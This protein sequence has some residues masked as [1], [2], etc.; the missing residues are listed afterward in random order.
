VS[1]LKNF[2]FLFWC[3]TDWVIAIIEITI[4]NNEG[5]GFF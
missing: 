1:I 3:E 2:S 4:A 5:S